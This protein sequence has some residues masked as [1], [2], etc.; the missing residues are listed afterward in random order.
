MVQAQPRSDRLL[1]RAQRV[2]RSVLS[3]GSSNCGA[4]SSATTGG[5]EQGV[6]QK[7]VDY[8]NATAATINTHDG[9]RSNS[10]HQSN[11]KNASADISNSWLR[12][13]DF[14]VYIP[15]SCLYSLF[16]RTEQNKIM[17]VPVLAPRY[18]QPDFK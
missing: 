14:R 6:L 11:G 4:T 3:H 18:E 13:P 17:G 10:D 8:S 12:I 5:F 1:P 15:N 9:V 2:R 16:S 7:G